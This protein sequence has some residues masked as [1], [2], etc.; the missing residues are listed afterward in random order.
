[1]AHLVVTPWLTSGIIPVA[2]GGALRREIAAAAHR[3]YDVTDLSDAE[4]ARI[5][6][7]QKVHACS[8]S[9]PL[10]AVTVRY[11]TSLPSLAGAR[12]D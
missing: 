10:L 2:Q 9:W 11:W 1:M 7:E 8:S 12:A 3:F 5:I 4:T 6:N